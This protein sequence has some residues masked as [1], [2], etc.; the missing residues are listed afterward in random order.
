MIWRQVKHKIPAVN[1]AIHRNRRLKIPDWWWGLVNRVHIITS[2]AIPSSFG[3]RQS[4][5]GH[6]LCARSSA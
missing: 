3:S 5:A 2:M 6:S 1:L 4:H